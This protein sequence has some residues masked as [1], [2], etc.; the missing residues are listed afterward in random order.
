MQAR[1]NPETYQS[2]KTPAKMGNSSLLHCPFPGRKAT[3]GNLAF[4]HSPSDLPAGPVYEFSIYHLLR[5]DQA[6]SLFDIE[7]LTVG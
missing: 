3:A 1:T 4:A 6:D 7:M 2:N 5:V